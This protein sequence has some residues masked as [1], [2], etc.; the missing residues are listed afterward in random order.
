MLKQVDISR[1]SEEILKNYHLEVASLTSSEIET[2]KHH[3]K[4][5]SNLLRIA[6]VSGGLISLCADL[7]LGANISVPLVIYSLV[8]SEVI[9][10]SLAG[11][12]MMTSGGLK[13]A[14]NKETQQS[15][16]EN[17]ISNKIYA[18]CARA[19]ARVLELVL[20]FASR[21]EAKDECA[22]TDKISDFFYRVYRERFNIGILN[23]EQLAREVYGDLGVDE[24]RDKKEKI[25]QQL[26]EAY[27]KLEAVVAS[28]V[29]LKD[30]KHVLGRSNEWSPVSS[31]DLDRKHFESLFVQKICSEHGFDLDSF[32]DM[33]P[34]DV[35]SARSLEIE[36]SRVILDLECDLILLKC[37]L[38]CLEA[39]DDGYDSEKHSTKQCA[40]GRS[41]GSDTTMV[42]STSPVVGP[43]MTRLYTK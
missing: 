38:C 39:K 10:C 18:E 12:K 17:E 4:Q 31:A 15:H 41:S 20:N 23:A 34:C 13:Q 26:K 29:L 21:L 11:C 8:S 36:I 1:I 32:Y 35:N 24:L 40:P 14:F 3:F 16:F 2:D 37:W 5:G 28:K 7:L 6:L 22:S 9:T 33:C 27:K 25:E 19:K 43:T 42:A 30:F